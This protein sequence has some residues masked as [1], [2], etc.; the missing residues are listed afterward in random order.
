MALFLSS[1]GDKKDTSE[2]KTPDKEMSNDN[3]TG[4]SDTKKESTDENKTA[5]FDT[6]NLAGV[7]STLTTLLKKDL[8]SMTEND[9][10]FVYSEISLGDDGNK[11]T[12]VMFQ[13]PYF[14]GSGG[15]TIYLLD[16]DYKT[17]S[18][19]SVSDEPIKIA[20]TT[21]NGWKDLLISSGGKLHVMKYNGKKYPGN[22]SVEAEYTGDGKQDTDVKFSPQ[23]SF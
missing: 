8:A 1:C 11:Q 2:T 5:S 10:K 3:T 23:Y 17:I 22:P 20:E 13:G 9:R 7:K 18:E 21:S 4:S 15:C 14:C 6:T 16:S 12:L 19:F